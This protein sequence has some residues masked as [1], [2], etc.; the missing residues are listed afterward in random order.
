[1]MDS[2]RH[3]GFFILGA[4]ALIA[5]AGLTYYLIRRHAGDHDPLAEANTKVSQ[6]LEMIS[7]IESRLTGATAAPTP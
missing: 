5:T 6:C 3:S 7:E 4:L 2:E 1:M